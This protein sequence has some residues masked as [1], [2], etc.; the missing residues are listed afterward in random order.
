MKR[1]RVEAARIDAL[2]R[3]GLA[4]RLVNGERHEAVLPAPEH[5]LAV[6]IDGV[7]ATVDAVDEA[8]ARVHVD[9]TAELPRPHIGRL[10]EQVPGVER[11]ASQRIPA[12]PEK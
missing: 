7:I 8:P 2:Q 9:G 1:A 4:A 3:L 5:L 12:A 11:P 10:L 6:E